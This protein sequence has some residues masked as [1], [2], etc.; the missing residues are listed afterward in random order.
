ML[1]HLL[2]PGNGRF[3]PVTETD[4]AQGDAELHVRCGGPCC[5]DRLVECEWSL[6][7]LHLR[8]AEPAEHGGGQPPVQQ[9]YDDVHI[10]HGQQRGHGQISQRAADHL[11]VRH[12]EPAD[13]DGDAAGERLHLHAGGHGQPHQ[14]AGAEQP[15]RAVELRRHQ[16]AD[17]RDH[18][19]R[20]QRQERSAGLQ[21]RS[22][23]Q[24][25]VRHVHVERDQRH[26]GHLQSR[27]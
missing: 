17:Q 13:G 24:Q 8:R 23:G 11:R 5:V 18:H 3:V 7:Q 2:E 22:G 15:L 19:Q 9:Q 4:D 27:R 12:A 16:P 26:T 25:A 21:P 20:A 6:G 14:C 1:A 10:R